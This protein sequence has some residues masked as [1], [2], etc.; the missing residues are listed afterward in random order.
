MTRIEDYFDAWSEFY[1]AELAARDPDDVGFYRERASAVDGPV[2]ELGC[3]TGR[4]TLELLAD[5][6]DAYGIDVSAEMLAT[7]RE[8]A[9]ER[10]LD[11]SV[12][13]ADQADFA[14]DREFDLVT[15]PA[16]VFLYNLTI[17]EQT[18]ALENVQDALA[19]G[20]EFVFSYFTPDL[21]TICE[22]Y[23]TETTVEF[24]YDGTTY[25]AAS[26]LVLED[27]VERIVRAERAVRD[28]NG[29]TVVEADSVFKLLPKREM[30]LLLQRTGFD[31]Y[32]VYGD[33]DGGELTAYSFDMV[34]VARCD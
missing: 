34:W 22:H 33:F 26:R 7:L 3:G 9:A 14:F 8:T 15:G 30:E 24:D 2:L 20:G 6:V 10:G 23:G 13:Q 4:I 32:E 27:K 17:A 12:R 28:E 1:D 18:A 31:D 19:S 25:T 11:P 29:E 16:D 21:N 5:G